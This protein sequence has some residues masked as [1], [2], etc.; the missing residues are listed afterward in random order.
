VVASASRPNLHGSCATVG[1]ETLSS[2][3]PWWLARRRVDDHFTD[4]RA[5][6][7]VPPRDAMSESILELLADV[8][9][10]A[11]MGDRT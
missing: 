6:R 11:E 5:G 8:P 2:A 4:G 9:A 10:A 7:R 3:K 1:L